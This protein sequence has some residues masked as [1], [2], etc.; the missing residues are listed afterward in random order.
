M[1]RML[2]RLIAAGL[3]W[4]QLMLSASVAM[5]DVEIHV[6]SNRADLLSGGD[7]LIDVTADRAAD[8][9]AAKVIADG[10]DVTA[11]FRPVQSGLRGLVTGLP[12]GSTRLEVRLPGGPGAAIV[13]TNHPTRGPIFSGAQAMPF[14]C[15]TEA[16]GLG[17]SQPPYCMVDKPRVELFYRSTDPTKGW[18]VFDPAQPPSDVASTTTTDG[19]TVP[20]IVRQE[21]GTLDRAN[22]AFAALWNP[23][24]KTAPWLSAPAPW[25]G[26]IVFNYGGGANSSHAQGN[27]AAI[28]P[29][30]GDVIP[31]AAANIPALLARG[32]TV[33]AQSLGRGAINRNEIV[34]AEATMMLK[35]R[36]AETLGPIR[37]AIGFGCSGGSV[38]QNEISAAYPGVLDG[39]VLC[40]NEVDWYSLAVDATDCHLLGTYFNTTSPALWASVVQRDAVE[41]TIGPTTCVTHARLGPVFYDPAYCI[42]GWLEPFPPETDWGYNAETNPSGVRC[43]LQD[44]QSAV[45]GQRPPG[46]WGP[47]EKKLGRGFAPRPYDNVGVQYGLKALLSGQI[48]AAQFVDLNQKLGC[49][50]IDFNPVPDRCA[51]PVDTLRTAYR[52]GQIASG[53]TWSEV[54]MLSLGGSGDQDVH[55][56]IRAHMSRA[57]LNRANGTTGNHVIWKQDQGGNASPGSLWHVPGGDNDGVVAAI[58]AMD[59]WLGAVVADTSEATRA[60]KILKD[61][62]ADLIDGCYVAG[63]RVSGDHGVCET[64]YPYGTVPRMVAGAPLSADVFKCQLRPLDIEDY[65]GTVPA[66]TSAEFAALQET[67]PDGVCDYSKPGVGYEPSVGWLSY[68]D[69]P[70]GTPLGEP[71]VS[72]PIPQGGSR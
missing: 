50:D 4:G 22:Y 51:A 15:Q 31:D 47:V 43:S 52:T 14:T 69:G 23:E 10:R 30:Q 58:S 36:I 68:A 5:A 71:P 26:K 40:A 13:L 1:N 44:E 8:L 25:N 46:Q 9:D 55:P 16:Q 6:L 48:T 62:P 11:S 24:R 38:N 67:F 7:A 37:Y 3:A 17:E 66:I 2:P 72:T 35:E 56:E 18:V 33:A 41:G 21:V 59:R 39:V 60:E 65:H 29:G 34:S 32:Y 53:H 45:F 27:V 42:V 61:K 19:K 49:V 12:L 63:V 28:K 54:A 64:L 57:R 70:G 20:F